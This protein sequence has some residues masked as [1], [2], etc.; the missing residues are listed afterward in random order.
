MEYRTMEKLGIAPSLL[1]FGCMRFPM[2]ADGKIDEK[3]A[4]EMIDLA[5]ESGVTYYDTAFPYHNGDSEPFMGRV[6]KKYDRD[7]FYLATKLPM[8][9]IASRDDAE[10]I[11]ED[12]R[13]RLQTD[14]VD[15]YLLHAL[16]QKSFEKVIELD[17]LSYCEQLKAEGKIR[18]LGFS[19][20][21]EYEVF[22]KILKYHKWDF[23]QIQY[24]YLDRKIQAGDKGYA[25]A[26]KM[27][28]P[29]IVMEPVKGGRLAA[30]PREIEK[31]LRDVNPGASNASFAL[32]WVASHPNVKVILSGM[33]T[34]DQVEENLKTF[35]EPCPLSQEE[36]KAVE[37]AAEIVQSRTQN[38]CT[39]CEY[40]MP[41]PFGVN[42][43]GNFRIWN[44]YFVYQD[45]KKSQEA[46]RK[47]KAEQRA[48][49]CKECG[50][51][52]AACP[53]NLSIRADLKRV[54]KDLKC[55]EE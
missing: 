14:Y 22:E 18:F 52:E 46:Y 49:Q 48:D 39:G 51:C 9:Q 2:T 13:K 41:C 10:K 25:L 40:C 53:Q 27:G 37:Q 24:N 23:C 12:Q 6:L 19:F 1:G 33:S 45:E 20:H 34:R 55:L 31:P 43:P 42:I 44:N 36:T 26:E 38:G 5:M 4:E 17:I 8:W 47:L 30:L 3:K 21:D 35:Q 16:D 50:K 7:R 15:F 11:F 29:M 28:V 54:T 32:R